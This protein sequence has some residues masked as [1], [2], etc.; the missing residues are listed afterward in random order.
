MSSSSVSVSGI[1]RM[2][3]TLHSSNCNIARRG[4]EESP[5]WCLVFYVSLA[6]HLGRLDTLI[7]HVDHRR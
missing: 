2:A 4:P 1:S 3:L 7:P 5:D 6:Q